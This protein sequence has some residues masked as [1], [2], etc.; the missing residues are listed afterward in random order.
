MKS[1]HGS[2]YST[3]NFSIN[4]QNALKF[5]QSYN[6][7]VSYEFNFLFSLRKFVD[8]LGMCL[9]EMKLCIHFSWLKIN[10]CYLVVDCIWSIIIRSP[11]NY[12]RFSLITFQFKSALISTKRCEIICFQISF[13]SP[14]TKSSSAC[15]VD[16]PIFVLLD[17]SKNS[18]TLES[19]S[20]QTCS[21]KIC[22]F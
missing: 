11:R 21:N 6:L 22:K 10:M 18:Y 16:I 5:L 15:G 8:K 14:V 4:S 2:E 1:P 12:S 17:S 13:L 7:N 3:E 9:S 20:F 19:I